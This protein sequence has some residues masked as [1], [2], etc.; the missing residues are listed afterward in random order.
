MYPYPYLI[1]SYR[2]NSLLFPL[3]CMYTFHL[4]S[5]LLF[6][7]FIWSL[8]P[9]PVPI[10]ILVALKRA[11]F[12]PLFL[13]VWDTSFLPFAWLGPTPFRHWLPF[14]PSSP[15]YHPFPHWSDQDSSWSDRF[16][17]LHMIFCMRLIHHPD[18]G[19]SIHRWNVSLLQQDYTVL[20]PRKVSSS[21]CSIV[22]IHF[23]LKCNST[24]THISEYLT[25]EILS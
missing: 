6:C 23:N 24:N 1:L 9:Q 22:K 11:I 21:Y 15:D 19:G 14:S 16:L 18:D 20:Y 12:F 25:W 5:S 3:S 4:S 7:F 10:T 8:F 17:Y 2:Y 13:C